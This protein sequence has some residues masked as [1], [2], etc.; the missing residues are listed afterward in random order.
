MYHF[1][2]W[3]LRKVDATQKEATST[4]AEFSAST[5]VVDERDTA[6]NIAV[7]PSPSALQ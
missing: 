1:G 5:G 3:G 6:Q 7:E 2:S 4:Q